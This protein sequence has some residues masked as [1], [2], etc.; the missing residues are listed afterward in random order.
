MKPTNFWALAGLVVV[1]WFL[2]DILA[3]PTGTSTLFT[4]INNLTKTTGSSV[5]GK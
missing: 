4:G 3:H 5:S 1:G 2:V